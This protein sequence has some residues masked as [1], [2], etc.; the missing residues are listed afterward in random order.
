MRQLRKM[1]LLYVSVGIFI[2]PMTVVHAHEVISNFLIATPY[3]D[4]FIGVSQK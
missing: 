1:G 3:E 2:F 4:G